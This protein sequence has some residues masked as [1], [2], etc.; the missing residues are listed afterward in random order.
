[1]SSG[2]AAATIAVAMPRSK[3]LPRL[4]NTAGERLTVIRCSGQLSALDNT[5]ARTRSRA[6]CND[7]SGSPTMVKPGIPPMC[8][9]MSTTVLEP[10]TTQHSGSAPNASEGP[11]G[12]PPWPA[13]GGT[14]APRERRTAIRCQ[15]GR[16]RRASGAPAD[17]TEHP[18]P[19]HRLQAGA[20]AE[21]AAGFDLTDDNGRS[22]ERD[23]VDLADVA[24][25]VAGR[26]VKPA[27]SRCRTATRSPYEPTPSLARIATTSGV[28]RAVDGPSQ[29]SRT[30]RCGRGTS[31]TRGVDNPN[32]SILRDL[33]RSSNPSQRSPF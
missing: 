7:A 5:A 9:S 14:D 10:R 29:W 32:T 17:A 30:P 11:A 2:S 24:A 23:D 33:R 22:V 8:T 18:R 15:V 31:V 21:A 1:M 6:S 26:I 20:V 3:W 28:E 19:G 16:A 4:G 25:P 27:C 12:A 13:R